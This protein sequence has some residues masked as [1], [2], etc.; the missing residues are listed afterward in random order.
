MATEHA[1]ADSHHG[2]TTRTYLV[3]AAV[4]T[5]ITAA[6]VWIFYVEAIKSSAAFVPTLLILSAVKFFTVVGFYMHLKYDHKIF[7]AVFGGP[8]LIAVSTIVAF[9]FLFGQLG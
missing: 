7:R 9:L 4:L 3:V 5:V 1:H 2:P 8:F 6:E